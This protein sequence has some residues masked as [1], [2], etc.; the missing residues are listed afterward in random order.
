MPSGGIAERVFGAV[1]EFGVVSKKRGGIKPPL[2]WE[3]RHRV[4]IQG[5]A[6]VIE[7]ACGKPFFVCNGVLTIAMSLLI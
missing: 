4:V 7:E 2:H 5:D 6:E 1:L 3:F